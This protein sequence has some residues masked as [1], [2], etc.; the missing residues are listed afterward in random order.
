MYQIDN[1]SASQSLP[2]S[3]SNGT[4]GFFTDGNPATGLAATVLPAEFM[5]MIMLEL[6]YL[7]TQSGQTLSKSDHTQ[8]TQAVKKLIAQLATVSWG[9]VT[10]KPG[11]LVRSGNGDT[12]TFNSLELSFAAPFIDFHYGNTAADYNL[13]IIN[14]Y[15]GTLTIQDLS[16]ALLSISAKGSTFTTP[17]AVGKTLTVTG[18][19]AFKS[20]LDVT[21]ATS[22]ASTLNVKGAA[23][24]QS[25]LAVS[26]AVSLY[27]TL[28]VDGV[29]TFKNAAKVG[30]TLDVSGAATLSSTLAVS[31][32]V[33]L[34]DS[35]T[36]AGGATFKSTLGVS[37]ALQLYNTLSVSGAVNLWN[38]AAVTGNV[39][40]TGS[41]T[42]ASLNVGP[43]SL[44]GAVLR[45]QASDT[46]NLHLW[47]YNADGSE[48]GLLWFDANS[49]F[50]LRAK[51]ASAGFQVTSAGHATAQGNFAAGGQI[52]CG[53]LLQAAGNVYAGNGAAILGTDGNVYGTVY[54]GWL[55]NWLSNNYL[56]ISNLR[57]QI[58]NQSDV[59]NVG[60]YATLW[61]SGGATPGQLVAGSL[62]T[63]GSYN[64][65][66][67][68][69]PDGTWRC[70][71][72]MTGGDKMALFLRVA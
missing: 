50:Y 39:S 21:G 20:T 30:T 10:D 8:V 12:P 34:K 66:S 63:Y 67:G 68:Q 64:Y 56:Q 40:V 15:D 9:N 49:N 7:V 1:D 70:M 57:T 29:A 26:D 71:G 69:S 24:L 5:N 27:K 11:N 6:T 41:V 65:K 36:V 46:G 13:R 44:T 28:S 35:L 2:P 38:G 25:T 31:G 14:D 60:T 53:G 47:F 18:A 59:G 19:G 32:A 16:G 72:Y 3:T 23:T 58:A 22:L 55:T 4:P 52:T 54:G 43:S 62:L 17:L 37:G 45:L 48:R 42:A 51:G 61:Y 33:D